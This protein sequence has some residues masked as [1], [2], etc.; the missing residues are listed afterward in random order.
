[1][2]E[3]LGLCLTSLAAIPFVFAWRKPALAEIIGRQTYKF[4]QDPVLTGLLASPHR[5]AKG[6]D[7]IIHDATRGFRKSYPELL[8]DILQT[9]YRLRTT[10]PSS[11]LNERGIVSNGASPYI[12][13]LV[14]SGYE[15]IVAF[16]AIRAVGGACMPMA[17]G[18]LPE[19][20]HYMVS[21]A[22]T[23]LLLVG[24]G[25]EEKATAICAFAS[26][27]GESLSWAPIASE[28]DVKPRKKPNNIDVEIDNNLRLDPK[29]PGILLFTSG[30]TGRPKGVVLPRECLGPGQVSS[31]GGVAF[32]HR[33]CHWIAGTMTLILPIL[34]GKTLHVLG[35]NASSEDILDALVLLRPTHV[36][37]TPTILREMKALVLSRGD[38]PERYVAGFQNLPS[39]R[40]SSA[41]IEPS[42]RE[43]WAGLTGL[44]F[45]NLYGMTEA[46]GGISCTVDGLN[47]SLNSPY[48]HYSCLYSKVLDWKTAAGG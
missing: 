19:E 33:A 42:L 32:S 12:G 38:A 17:S 29:G 24:E 23:S 13:I 15:F 8:N 10:L 40:C 11:V 14:R 7:I 31:T 25:C 1:M 36:S 35:E 22:K 9:A 16:F 37:F 5:Q 6:S 26:A 4:P 48:T 3:Y 28:V 21:K 34:S 45:A 46:G 18:I 20:A 27:Q 47:V 39:L 30:T 43:F 44:P 2:I 41:P